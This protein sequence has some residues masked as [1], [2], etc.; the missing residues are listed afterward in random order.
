VHA[1]KGGR[2]RKVINNWGANFGVDKGFQQ[3]MLQMTC[4]M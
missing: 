1:Q 3:K 4:E 2:G